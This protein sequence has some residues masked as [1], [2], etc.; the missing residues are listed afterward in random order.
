V[1]TFRPAQNLPFPQIPDPS[2]EITPVTSLAMVYEYGMDAMRI[3]IL[4]FEV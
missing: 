1:W 3:I 2:L 4:P